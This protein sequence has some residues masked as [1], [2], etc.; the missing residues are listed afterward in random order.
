[1]N[2]MEEGTILLIAIQ[3][4]TSTRPYK[5]LFKKERQG[6]IQTSKIETNDGIK[7]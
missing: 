3:K 2:S 5:L 1:M 7:R 4:R 6:A